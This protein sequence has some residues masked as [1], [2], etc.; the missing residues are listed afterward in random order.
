MAR[1]P[2]LEIYKFKLKP[3][4]TDEFK[5]F[6][7]F[8]NEN[9]IDRSRDKK[10]SISKLFQYAINNISKG[11]S[12]DDKSSLKKLRIFNKSKLSSLNRGLSIHS[13]LNLFEGIIGG[14]IYGAERLKIN[15][16]NSDV[17]ELIQE[18][19]TIYQPF[20]VLI[21]TPLD[22][23]K[24]LLMVQ[25]YSDEGV[26][27]TVRK[28]VS[29][30]FKGNKYNKAEIGPWYPEYLIKEFNEGKEIQKLIFSK[31]IVQSRIATKAID[32][33]EEKFNVK[34]IVTPEN[35]DSNKTGKS[36]V[37]IFSDY[38]FKTKFKDFLLSDFIPQLYA[39]TNQSKTPR[40]FE[41]ND[42]ENE[43]MPVVLLENHK[44]KINKNG[45]PDF[46]ELKVFCLD[47]LNNI[48]EEF[49]GFSDKKNDTK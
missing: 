15:A 22:Y 9:G 20:Y 45:T 28:F 4:N 39:K 18:G 33:T 14:G 36:L 43:I 44:I 34:I 3:H 6:Q 26:S 1:T 46:E 48:K 12:F 27:K 8:I 30:L 16:N 31:T 17:D 41:M 13:E 40:I 37:S 2:K 47:L 10:D 23:D 38:V 49:R 11:K 24:G 35:M 29:G 21:Y 42:G 32:E 25:T 5:T 7:D 19:D